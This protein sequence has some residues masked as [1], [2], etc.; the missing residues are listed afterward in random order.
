[1]IRTYLEIIDKIEEKIKMLDGEIKIRMQRL[2]ED[3]E[4]AISINGMGFTS[5]STI[6]AEIGNFRDFQTAEQLASWCGL[7]PKVSQSADVL[8]TGSITKQGSKHIRRMLVQVAHIIARSGNSKLKKFFMRIQVKKGT[9]KAI[10]A[11]ARKLVCILHHLL[12][13]REKYLDGDASK[14]RKIKK[15][16]PD[17]NLPPVQMA[18]QEMINVLVNAGYIVKHKGQMSV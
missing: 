16:D 12:V 4:I 18:E 6:L 7:T 8:V 15:F 14:T 9:K 17:I 5:A 13:N 2:K 10:V 3:L 11:L 1:M